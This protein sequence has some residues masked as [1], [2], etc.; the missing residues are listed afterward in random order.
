[1]SKAEQR[2]RIVE[3]V[4]WLLGEADFDGVHL[5]AETVRN[6]DPGFLLLLDEVKAAIGPSRKLSIAG[7]D[8]RP[9]WINVLPVVGGYKWDGSYYRQV[10]QRVDQIAVMSYD[11]LMPHPALYRLWMRE[12]VRGISN[13][14]SGLGTE[15]LMGLSVSREETRTHRPDAENMASGLAGVCAGAARLSKASHPVDGVIIYAAWEADDSDWQ[16]WRGWL[17]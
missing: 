5:D 17:R 8:W 7:N 14:V 16:V 13:S 2:R 10:A 3:F 4:V 6:W 9:R 11:S 12:Q 15:L 1:L